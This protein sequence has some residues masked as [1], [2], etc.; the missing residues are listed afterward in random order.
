MIE[1]FDFN[2]EKILTVFT[3]S[4]GSRWNRKTIKAKTNMVE[5][6]NHKLLLSIVLL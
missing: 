3:I 5:I 6:I 1:L 2:I 4:P